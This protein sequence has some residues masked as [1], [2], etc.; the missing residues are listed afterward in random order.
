MLPALIREPTFEARTD[1]EVTKVNLSSDGKRATGVTYVDLQGQEWEQPA[2]IVLVCA[3]ALFNVRL[4]LLSGIGKP[5]DPATE[6]VVGRNYAYQITSS[7]DVFF[8]DKIMNPFIGAGALGMVVDEFNGD[9]FDHGPHGFVGGGYL[10]GLI[11][12][13][14][15]SD[16]PD[17]AGTPKWGA[18]WK[19]AVADNYR[20]VT[21]V[22]AQ[23][24]VMSHRD[25]YLDLDPTYRDRF[26]RPLMRMTFDFTDNELKMANCMADR[27]V[28][29]AKAMKPRE[30]QA[31]RAGSLF[32]GALP[33]HA[34]HRRRGDGQ[35]PD[36]QRREPLPA[37]LGR[38]ERVR[39]RRQR[40]SAERR[41]QPD[42]HRGR[43]DLLG[44][45]CDQEQI[46][47]KPRSAGADHEDRRC[48]A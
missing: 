46:P 28:E 29:I 30:S 23:G 16:A 44:A 37:E 47:E 19:K 38:A 21:N 25:N 20:S 6:G 33:D 34:Q 3:Y 9:N 4:M 11:P 2:D 40:L 48:K 15:R 45:G 13:G 18:Q 8:D 31:K 10:R 14:G 41:L 42:R 1:S 35:R 24:S 17:A 32:G 43:A 7:V 26:G 27:A 39:H 22:G 5:Y 36:D 12:T